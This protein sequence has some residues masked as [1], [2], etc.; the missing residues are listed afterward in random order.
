MRSP[1]WLWPISGHVAAL[2]RRECRSSWLT[3]FPL[4]VILGRLANTL[5]CELHEWDNSSDP[6]TLS[7]A[8]SF[9]AAAQRSD[10]L[11]FSVDRRRPPWR[12]LRSS[13]KTV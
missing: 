1:V 2:A 12:R 10:K 5:E 9:A 11:M 13:S 7:A 8:V 4:A 3:S 6:P